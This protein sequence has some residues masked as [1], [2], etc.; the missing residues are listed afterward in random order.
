MAPLL[1]RLRGLIGDPAGAGQA[2]SDDELQDVADGCREEARYLPLA[3]E[4]TRAAGGGAAY[5]SFSAPTGDWEEGPEL[6]DAT[7]QVLIPAISDCRAGRWRFETEPARPVTLTGRTFD[8]ARA[9]AEVLEAW[10]ARVK[11]EYD[12]ASSD[13][14]FERG[15]QA[16]A[17]QEL[18]A[19][20]RRR[21]RPRTAVQ[22]R[23]DVG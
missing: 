6:Y 22:T 2:W 9:A 15:Q 8:L 7:Y 17:M 16:R 1:S 14:R 21:A 4:E 18:A 5:L 19:L 12:F 10:A 3:P 13:Q 23:S 20:Y 11:R